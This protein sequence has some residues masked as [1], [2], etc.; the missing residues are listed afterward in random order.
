MLKTKIIASTIALTLSTIFCTTYILADAATLPDGVWRMSLRSDTKTFTKI[1]GQTFNP[2]GSA[3]DD[4]SAI[5]VTNY[6]AKHIQAFQPLIANSLISP[7]MRL[8]KSGSDT[9]YFFD[10]AYGITN[11]LSVGFSI[12]YRKRVVNYSD[13]YVETFKALNQAAEDG[14]ITGL[15]GS[16]ITV[17]P[18]TAKGEGLGDIV[19]G[20][21]YSFFENFSVQATA[22]AGFLK[23]GKDNTEIAK[24]K[25]GKEELVTGITGDEYTLEAYY[26]W[27]LKKWMTMELSGIFTHLTPDHASGLDNN[28]SVSK[29]DTF[30]LNWN[31]VF[32]VSEKLGLACG[33]YYFVGGKDKVKNDS[34]DWE[35]LARSDE[36]TIAGKIQLYYS[37]TPAIRPW[38]SAEIP[39]YN[40]TVNGLYNYPGRL[41]TD[42]VWE[43]G[44]HFFYK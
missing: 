17:P 4:F 20:F 28:Y 15:S 5:G 35:T 26:D 6:A 24:S 2:D 12:P 21:R 30:Q 36:E 9:N 42:V 34:N 32:K 31:N 23:T 11:K 22:K 7:D 19:A 8:L 10:L 3:N 44:V 1:S 40:K 18:H 37:L 13:E 43:F 33:A 14:H 29:G 16:D 27:K 41:S 25:D 38:V 39:L